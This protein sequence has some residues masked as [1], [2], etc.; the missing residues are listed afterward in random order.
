MPLVLLTSPVDFSLF[1]VLTCEIQSNS[2]TEEARDDALKDWV[3]AEQ[4]CGRTL[5]VL[6]SRGL[7]SGCLGW[8]NSAGQTKILCHKVLRDPRL[9]RN[10][11]NSTK[12]VNAGPRRSSLQGAQGRATRAGN[13]PGH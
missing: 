3:E 2:N 11:L 13:P 8:Q 4:L 1:L 5:D 12:L 10:L 6:R 9:N 7:A